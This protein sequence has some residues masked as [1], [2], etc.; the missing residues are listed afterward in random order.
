MGIR[1]TDIKLITALALVF[2]LAVAQFDNSGSKS[3]ISEFVGSASG[4]FSITDGDTIKMNGE[5][6]GT[7]LVGFNTPET[8]KPLCQQEFALGKKATRRLEELVR[9]ASLVE[10]EKVACACLPGTQGTAK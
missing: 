8:Y 4:G 5:R 6:K 9:T 1:K 10:V 7:R 3:P 2:V